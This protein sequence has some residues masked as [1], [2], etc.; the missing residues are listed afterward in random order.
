MVLSPMPSYLPGTGINTQ[1]LPLASTRIDQSNKAYSSLAKLVTVPENTRDQN[2]SPNAYRD[3][4][5]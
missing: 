5:P 3:V 1:I 4:L 2:A